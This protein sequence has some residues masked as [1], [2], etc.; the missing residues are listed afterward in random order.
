MLVMI[1]GNQ[2]NYCFENMIQIYIKL[3][4]LH[5]DTQLGSKSVYFKI[6]QINREM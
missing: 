2:R 5:D 6:N 1:A 4:I 3:N